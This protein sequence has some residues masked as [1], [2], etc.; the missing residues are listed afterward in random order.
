MTTSPRPD[1]G[2]AHLAGGPPPDAA[3]RR[4]VDAVA[5][6]RWRVGAETAIPDLVLVG[7]VT[8]VASN[9]LEVELRLRLRTSDGAVWLRLA[10][11][12][13][14]PRR[15]QDRTSQDRPP[16]GATAQATTPV[17]DDGSGPPPVGAP[18][19][20]CTDS[21]RA[22]AGAF[23][24]DYLSWDEKAPQRRGLALAGYLPGLPL[25]AATR[26]GWTGRGRQR[27][28]LIVPGA[29]Q[30]RGGL[31]RVTVAVQV[32]LFAAAGVPPRPRP[33]AAVLPANR[34]PEDPFMPCS[35]PAPDDP[36]W[37][38]RDRMWLELDVLVAV[39]DGQLSVDASTILAPIRPPRPG[40]G[41]GPGG[42]LPPAAW[43]A[44]SP[45]PA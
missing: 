17:L 9:M 33:S 18:T 27:V 35:A 15:S 38:A 37:S 16:R 10:V 20:T 22:F 1:L 25:A 4:A 21:A 29:L 19:A 26:A 30:H 3:V 23:A 14:A 6:H 24:A 45:G 43:V 11:P 28:E 7:A 31:I 2:E 5:G 8:P 36:A 41:H 42:A 39:R 12:V 13:A 40:A 44:D 34:A 32:A